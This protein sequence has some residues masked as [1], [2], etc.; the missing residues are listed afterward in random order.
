M[1]CFCNH[2]LKTLWSGLVFPFGPK[3][4]LKEKVFQGFQVEEP[5]G[6]PILL[7]T[8]SFI[9]CGQRMAFNVFTFGNLLRF[10]LLAC[11]CNSRCSKD[12]GKNSVFS[13][14]RILH[15]KCSL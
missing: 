8:F 7:F 10:Y 12:T 1:W 9:Y 15:L 14:F 4:C 5:F 3:S 11:M 6:F 13:V 2:V